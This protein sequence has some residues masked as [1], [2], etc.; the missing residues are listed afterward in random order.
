MIEFSKNELLAISYFAEG[1]NSINLLAKAMKLSVPQTYTIVRKLLEKKIILKSKGLIEFEKKTFI[2]LLV[3]VLQDNKNLVNLFFGKRLCFLSGIIEKPLSINLISL[4]CDSAPELVYKFI[5][6]AREI[7]L[8]NKTPF[9]Y[10][11]NSEEWPQIKE[12]L[13]ELIKQ[14]TLFDD[15]LPIGSKIYQKNKKG[16]LFSLKKLFDKA[17]LTAFSIFDKYGIKLN[18]NYNYYFFPN[19][20]LS[21]Q[22]VF[23]H[24][25]LIA[26]SEKDYRLKTY[27]C[28]F[29]LK[30]KNN[31][32]DSGEIVQKIIDSFIGKPIEGYPSREEI[33]QKA[34]LY[35][36]RI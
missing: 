5:H 11:L 29:Y 6:E 31:L 17:S 22:D 34:K 36:I 18:S 32:S 8:V 1:K 30:N 10:L 24:A 9:G 20:K 15:I 16:I 4:K 23:D 27:V 19:T 25:A 3:R 14:D 28:L 7:A 33:L 26:E 35:D 21:I 2:S 12:L 13:I